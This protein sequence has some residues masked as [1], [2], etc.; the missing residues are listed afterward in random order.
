M[1]SPDI[2]KELDIAIGAIHW[3]P[4]MQSKS[5]PSLGQFTNE[6]LH[7]TLGVLEKDIDILAHPTRIFTRSNLKIPKEVIDP[8]IDKAIKN[9]VALEI[10]SHSHDPNNIFVKRCIEKGAKIAIGTDSHSLSEFGD[11][12][13]HK[14][15]L[16][17]CGVKESDI[18]NLL[19]VI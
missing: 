15:I 3:L 1:L 14:K 11:F 17:E 2:K 6:F 10:N 9:N 4:C 16:S 7:F 13:F 19:F 12:S 18:Q 5:R 8:V